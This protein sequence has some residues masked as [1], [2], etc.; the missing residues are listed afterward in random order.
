[1]SQDAG[2]VNWKPSH[3]TMLIDHLRMVV[4]QQYSKQW[5]IIAGLGDYQLTPLE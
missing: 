2:T 4:K 5:R 3:I 1:M